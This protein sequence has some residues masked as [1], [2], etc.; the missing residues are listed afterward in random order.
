[1]VRHSY[2]FQSGKR[3]FWSKN[4]YQMR[5]PKTDRNRSLR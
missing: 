4:E 1:V 3:V 5:T 2:V